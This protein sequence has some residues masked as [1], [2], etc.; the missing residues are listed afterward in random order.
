MIRQVQDGVGVGGDAVI[1]PQGVVLGEDIAHRDLQISGETILARRALGLQQQG[2]AEGLD[3]VNFAGEG[4]VQVVFAV[5]RFQL[6]LF[7]AHA[8][9]G[10]LDAVGV[11]PHKCAAAGTAGGIEVIFIVGKGVVA[12]H[13]IHRPMFC[14][15]K[16]VFDHAAVIQ[17][18]DRQP[19]GVRH[20]VLVDLFTILGHAKGLGAKL[21]HRAS[22]PFSK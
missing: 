6:V 12:H 7:A 3:V 9:L 17:H 16:D 4:A 19:A 1:H 13:D 8:E 10:V 21:C 14:G 20:D 5:V 2:I 11:P 22:P 15:N 18:T